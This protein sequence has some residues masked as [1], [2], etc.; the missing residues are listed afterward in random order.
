[1]AA[2]YDL[3]QLRDLLVKHFSLE[4]LHTLAFDL[5]VDYE[6]LAGAGKEARAREFLLYLDR[7]G[8]IPQLLDAV[9][10]QRPE[11]RWPDAYGMPDDGRVLSGGRSR[12]GS[13]LATSRP[14][15][16]THLRSPP[17]P[18]PRRKRPAAPPSSSAT[19]TRTR[20]GRIAW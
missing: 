18:P 1:M 11:V 20:R 15:R 13:A 5:G 10:R 6:S 7:R 19:A 4:E 2:S 16:P 3:P 9:R 14:E 17:S 8:R 12:P